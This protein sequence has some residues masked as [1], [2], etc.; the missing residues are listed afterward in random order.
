MLAGTVADAELEVK[1]TLSPA[2]GA[3]PLSVTVPSEDT[4]PVTGLGEMTTVNSVGGLIVMLAV[5]FVP[6]SDAVTVANVLAAT[7][8]V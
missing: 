2:A 5:D 3:A 6:E 1:D 8:I 7:G 4:P